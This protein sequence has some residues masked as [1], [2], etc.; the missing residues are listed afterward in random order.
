[1]KHT[2]PSTMPCP[3]HPVTEISIDTA[4]TERASAKRTLV[5]FEEY[6]SWVLA[7]E[8]ERRPYDPSKA[9]RK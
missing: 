6:L 5:T 1:M 3:V 2:L 4:P 7:T 8:L 9:V